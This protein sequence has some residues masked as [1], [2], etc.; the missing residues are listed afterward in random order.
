MATSRPSD[1]LCIS[2]LRS[3]RF[4][5]LSRRKLRVSC[6]HYPDLH[7]ELLSNIATVPNEVIESVAVPFFREVITAE[8]A[9]AALAFFSSV[10]GSVISTK[11][12]ERDPPNLTSSELKALEDFGSSPPGLALQLFLGNSR[13]LLAIQTAIT[14]HP[15]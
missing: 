15:Q 9:Q 3:L 6:E 4:A 8:G 13:V 12:V 2:T 7:A 11:L 5:E 1:E 14:D 10:E